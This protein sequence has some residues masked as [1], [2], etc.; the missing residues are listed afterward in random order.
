MT[1]YL[2]LLLLP[3]I[4]M[5]QEDFDLV[6]FEQYNSYKEKS[7]ETRRFKHK[8]IQ[9]LIEA[10]GKENGFSVTSLGVSIQGR[11]ISLMSVGTGVADVFWWS[12]M[13]GD[14]STDTLGLCVSV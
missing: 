7:I 11:R 1:K 5:G 6:L 10:L 12:Q 13:H 4:S 8:D 2:L 14:A 3:L 9:P